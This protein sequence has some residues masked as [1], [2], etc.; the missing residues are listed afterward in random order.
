VQRHQSAFP[1]PLVYPFCSFSL[2]SPSVSLNFPADIPLFFFCV[3][4]FRS[5]LSPPS[6]F[7]SLGFPLRFLPFSLFFWPLLFLSFGSLFIGAG[8][9]GST[10][11]RPIGAHA[12]GA[13]LLHCHGA[14]SGGQ[15]RRRLRDTAALASHHEMG[16]V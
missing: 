12:W 2:F 6:W 4:Q 16:G 15:W 3:S 8:G 11:P 10:L 9:A 13:R 5:F 14:D 1:S 7:L